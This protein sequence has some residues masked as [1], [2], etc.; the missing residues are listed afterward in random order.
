MRK[1]NLKRDCSGKF[2]R[3]VCAKGISLYRFYQQNTEIQS[4]YG[5]YSTFMR[6]YKD[7]VKSSDFSKI[8]GEYLSRGL[9]DKQIQLL[10]EEM[11]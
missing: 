6:Y 3:L 9:T 10:K 7:M 11:L 2:I 1:N 8:F 4:R 5:T